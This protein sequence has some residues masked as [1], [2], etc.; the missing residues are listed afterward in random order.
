MRPRSAPVIA[1]QTAWPAFAA[2]TAASTSG[3]AGDLDLGED[4][5]GRGVDGRE[6]LAPAGAIGGAADMVAHRGAGARAAGRG[7]LASSGRPTRWNCGIR[8]GGRHGAGGSVVELAV[9]RQGR[10][11]PQP[12]DHRRDRH[13]DRLGVLAA[14]I[15]CLRAWRR[16][17]SMRR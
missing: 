1:P 15:A 12:V 5:A 7:R 13:G 11:Q 10:A 17:E 14:G 3:L 4:L 9:A 2:A 6:G 16:F 8:E